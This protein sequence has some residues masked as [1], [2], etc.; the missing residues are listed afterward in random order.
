MIKILLCDD[1]VFAR[2]AMANLIKRKGFDVVVAST[3]EQCIELFKKE[4]PTVVFLDV[5]LP[6]LDG[7]HIHKYL[8]ELKPDVSVYYITGSETVFTEENARSEGAKG[9][10]PKPVD[11]DELFKLLDTIKQTFGAQI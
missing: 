11:I 8:R 5:M 3:G 7:D 6:D 10:L 1:E 9:Y 4:N 2:D